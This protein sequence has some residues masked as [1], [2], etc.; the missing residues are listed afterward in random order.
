MM[1]NENP[2]PN[3]SAAQLFHG[4]QRVGRHNTPAP[5]TFGLQQ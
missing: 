1:P 3:G 4:S 5:G 2:K